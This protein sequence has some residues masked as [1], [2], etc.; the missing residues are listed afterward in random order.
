MTIEAMVYD[1][2]ESVGDV[3]TASEATKKRL[4]ISFGRTLLTS[5]GSSGGRRQWWILECLKRDSTGNK[6]TGP[7]SS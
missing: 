4:T 7:S 2:N 6:G 1:W 3:S 5:S